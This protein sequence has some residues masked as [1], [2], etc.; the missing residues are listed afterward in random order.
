[1]LPLLLPKLLCVGHGEVGNQEVGIIGFSLLHGLKS[2]KVSDFF[3]SK[4]FGTCLFSSTQK[5]I[6]TDGSAVKKGSAEGGCYSLILRLFTFCLRLLAWVLFRQPDISVCL[7][8]CTV[9]RARLR[10]QTPLLQ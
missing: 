3:S 8:L 4:R 7:R 9:A 5:G 6:K 1:M 2:G 10:L